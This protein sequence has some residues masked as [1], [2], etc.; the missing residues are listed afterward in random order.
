M[1]SQDIPPSGRTVVQTGDL[2]IAEET[3]SRCYLPLRLR[4]TLPGAALNARFDTVDL[5]GATVGALRFGKEVRIVT[6]EADNFHVNVPLA[7][8]AVSR[9]GTAH[10]VVTRPGSAQVFMPGEQAD[11]RWSNSTQQL[12]VMVQKSALERHL[13]TLLNAD[14]PRP[15]TFTPTMDLRSPGGRT[16]THVLRL[17]DHELRRGDGLLEH[18]LMRGTLERL[19]AESLLSGHKHNYTEQLQRLPAQYGSGAIRTAMDLLQTHPERPWSASELATEVGLSVRAL[20]A[21]FRATALLGPMSY[22][23][24]IRLTRAHE[25]L[26][27]AD[28]ATT[29]VGS[30]ARRWGFGHL[31]RFA[32]SYAERYGVLPSTTLRGAAGV[33]RDR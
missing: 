33:A 8:Q 6:A 31:G 11:L 9:A 15:L 27:H 23:R 17:V 10:Q 22:L 13:A 30:V 29:T 18:G 32:S 20:H 5:G 3:L 21:G 25:D 24:R 26:L 19:L 7:G 16:W 4:S 2:D 28:P 12:C 1:T 14:L